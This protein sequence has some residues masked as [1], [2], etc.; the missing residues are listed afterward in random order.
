M[1]VL[2]IVISVNFYIDLFAGS[3]SGSTTG[4]NA[5]PS[6]SSACRFPSTASRCDYCTVDSAWGTHG[7][8]APAGMDRCSFQPEA[9]SIS[10]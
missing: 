3:D 7:G 5:E 1:R 10:R 6:S 9:S 4:T 2:C 8:A